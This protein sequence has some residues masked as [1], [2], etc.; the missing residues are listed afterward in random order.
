LSLLL[1]LLT[2]LAAAISSSSFSLLGSGELKA[3]GRGQHSLFFPSP[4]TPALHRQNR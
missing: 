3:A 2:Q 4:Q 1:L